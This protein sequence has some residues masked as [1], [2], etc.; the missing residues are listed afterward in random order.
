[1]EGYGNDD[2]S[3][4]T[5]FTFNTSLMPI[6]TVARNN[7]SLHARRSLYFFFTT[8]TEEEHIILMDLKLC[9]CSYHLS[10]TFHRIPC[11]KWLTEIKWE[12]QY[13][14]RNR[15]LP[16]FIKLIGTTLTYLHVMKR[17]YNTE[18]MT[19][20]RVMILCTRIMILSKLLLMTTN[21]TKTYHT[22][23]V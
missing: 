20:P 22:Y 17:F 10:D 16:G 13:L 11:Q 7:M 9:I 14:L 2:P 8:A 21:T 19:V 4:A 6:N 23:T 1:M 3:L 18:S 5:R 12:T 15:L